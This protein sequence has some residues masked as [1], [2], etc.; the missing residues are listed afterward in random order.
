MLPRP[1]IEI[2]LGPGLDHLQFVVADVFFLEL[3]DFRVD[4]SSH[5]VRLVAGKRE[6]IE[7]KQVRVLVA[8]QTGETGG[9]RGDF[10]VAYQRAIQPR[11][12]AF[13]HEVGNRVVDCVI[14]VAVVGPVIALEIEGLRLFMKHDP[15]LGIL[16]RLGRDSLVRLG[17]GRGYGQNISR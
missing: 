15:A 6:G 12:A 1:R 10:L 14:G 5:F 4:G 9:R 2:G 16:R 8:G 17:V 7:G 13:G 3:V 11:S